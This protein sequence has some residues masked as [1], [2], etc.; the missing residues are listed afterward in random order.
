MSRIWV[1]RIEKVQLTGDGNVLV[2][3]ATGVQLR[4]TTIGARGLHNA[5]GKFLATKNDTI[6]LPAPTRKDFKDLRARVGEIEGQ[7]RGLG[8]HE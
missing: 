6:P 4:M 7:L 1:G 8:G 2:S 3:D 5:L